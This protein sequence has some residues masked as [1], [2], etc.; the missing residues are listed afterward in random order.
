MILDVDLSQIEWRV[1]A[2]LTMD[3]VMIKEILDKVDQ[4]AAACVD[5][6]ELPLNKENRTDAKIFNFRAIY[7]N[8][9]TAAWAYFMDHK[10]PSFTQKKWQRI[11]DGFYEK[12][13]GMFYVHQDWIAQVRKSGQI[14]GPTGRVW[15]FEKELKKGVWDYSVTRIRNYPVQGTAGDVIKVA[16]V[17][18]RKRLAK[19]PM[20]KMLMT[21][22]DSIIFDLPAELAH[23]VARICIDTFNEI[24]DLML[25]HFGWKMPV[26]I[27][28]E[29]DI[30]PSWGELERII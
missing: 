21:V 14:V 11:M 1:V 29:A 4:H 15:K 10:M 8:P 7:A 27:D 6:M 12:Y 26:P 24:P 28:G 2:C 13:S 5:L 16:L 18:L 19:F 3:Q 22:H 25:K 30:G 17:Y 23:E 9:E 20:V